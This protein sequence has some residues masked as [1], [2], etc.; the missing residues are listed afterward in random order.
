MALHGRGPGGPKPMLW[1]R[2]EKQKLESFFAQQSTPTRLQWMF[3]HDGDTP[4][5]T[6]AP[7][8]ERVHDVALDIYGTLIRKGV[9]S[10]PGEGS[11]EAVWLLDGLHV[12]EGTPQAIR[13][14]RGGSAE[15]EIAL[16]DGSPCWCVASHLVPCAEEEP[17]DHVATAVEMD[18]D[19]GLR[20]DGRRS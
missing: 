13:I 9:G 4:R 19:G 20:R 16:D 3:G 5:Q 15:I 10:Q 7:V 8:G 1:A 6:S 17:P 18:W 14:V 2:S 11:C 12:A